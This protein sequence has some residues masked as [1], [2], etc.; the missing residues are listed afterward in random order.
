VGV[1]DVNKRKRGELKVNRTALASRENQIAQQLAK[2]RQVESKEA[3]DAA[4]RAMQGGQSRRAL[5]QA[6]ERGHAQQRGER[7]NSW[8]GKHEE[9]KRAKSQPGP[10]G[11]SE[12]NTKKRIQRP[13]AGKFDTRYLGEKQNL[14]PGVG[15]GEPPEE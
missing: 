10:I 7:R 14:N 2:P 8:R 12:T 1:V 9:Y 11:P 6:I 4:S 13:S 15:R 5:A 3:E